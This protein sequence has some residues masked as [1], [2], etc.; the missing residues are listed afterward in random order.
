MAFVADK[1]S[2]FVPESS[3]TPDEGDGKFTATSELKAAPLTSFQPDQRQTHG[4]FGTSFGTARNPFPFMN[5]ETSEAALVA[6]REP[7][8][9]SRQGLKMGTDLIPDAQ[10]PSFWKN[11][12][13]NT[14]KTVGEVGAEFSAS[15]LDPESLLTMGADKAGLFKLVGKGLK[16]FSPI[17][18]NVA[19]TFPTA[20][21]AIKRAFT[22][23]FGQPKEYVAAAEGRLKNIAAG[24]EKA[25]EVGKSLSAGL[26]KK[27]QQTLGKVLVGQA[28]AVPGSKM[29][30]I[31]EGARDELTRVG[32]DAVK[33]GLLDEETYL[34]NVKEYMPRLYR[35]YESYTKPSWLE[36]MANPPEPPPASEVFGA[37]PQKI[38]GSRF[39]GRG[40]ISEE[41]RT[42]MGEITEPAYPVAKGIAEITKD[43][44]TAKLFKEV[45]DNPEWSSATAQGDYVLLEGKKLGALNGKYVH[46]EIARDIQEINKMPGMV[47]RIYND[48]LSKWKFGKV[49]LNPATHFRNM[50]NNSIFLD[51]SGVD[52]LHQPKLLSR[53]LTE[54]KSNGAMFN[55]AKEAG[56][57][58]NEFYGNE[59]QKLLD[60]FDKPGETV[61]GKMLNIVRE[62]PD[63][64]GEIY[65]AEEKWFKMAKFI[66][67]REKGATVKEAATEAEKWLF[68]YGKISPATKF[69]R[70]SPV[71]APFITFTA[72]AVPRLLESAMNNP[73]RLYKYKLMT[74]AFENIARE[75]F[76]IHDDDVKKIKRSARGTVMILPVKDH[77]GN[78]QTLDLSYILPWGDITESGGLFGPPGISPGG[79]PLR[80]LLDVAP[81]YNKSPYTGKPVYLKSDSAFS[82]KNFQ[83]S[84]AGKVVE[85]V[86]RQAVPSL[87]PA[88]PGVTK[89]GY[90]FQKVMNAIA[91]TPDYFGRVRDVPTVLADV[92]F[93]L[94]VSPYSEQVTDVFAKSGLLKERD[95]IRGEL[96][97]K[98][99][100][101]SLSEEQKQKAKVIALEK[102]SRL[103]EKVDEATK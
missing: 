10:T 72:K 23:R 88:V 11:I 48:L 61:F 14:P 12:I 49:V 56:V 68:N 71:G 22:Y 67:E 38:S 91:G 58:G 54:I 42:A 97:S 63:K 37:N 99:A 73:M 85:Y 41:A 92:V 93:G 86:F 43:V 50:M 27:E 59:I 79:N 98:L 57:F 47:E 1:V 96:M 21:K 3:F 44:E 4:L 53:S 46:P 84:K 15:M 65:Q 94:K 34:K 25:A 102:L 60:N 90:S 55:E 5:P 30:Q 36:R 66:A 35:K 18:D 74:D 77:A 7:G 70:Q 52:L 32:S 62:T 6:S 76:D 82:V 39:M 17:V 29:A 75:R 78:L 24:G 8:R 64:M 69:F 2:S 26:G 83:D 31:A 100:N 103:K 16:A 95:E 28:S 81:G 13:L 19:E 89:G 87:T 80:T 9:L 40:D 51:Q 101:Q 33:A 20:S 45:A